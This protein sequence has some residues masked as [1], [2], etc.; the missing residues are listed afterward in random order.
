MSEAMAAADI[1]QAGR[2][3]VVDDELGVRE[4]CR[5]ILCSEGFDVV[6]AGDGKAGL[7]QFQE[8]GPFSVLLVDLQMPRMS[9]LELMRMSSQT[10]AKVIERADGPLFPIT[11]PSTVTIV[12]LCP[13]R[14]STY[15]ICAA[16]G[17]APP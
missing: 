5:K 11:S 10:S 3:L 8:R 6:T 9:G 13:A 16:E 17:R 15:S 2:I 1:R 14:D 4:G 7:E 12:S